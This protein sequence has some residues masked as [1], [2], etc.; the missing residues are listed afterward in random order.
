MIWSGEKWIESLELLYLMNLLKRSN[1]LPIHTIRTHGAA[2][3]C[4]I[5]SMNRPTVW[6][7]EHA[8][9]V[10][11]CLHQWQ[12]P[13]IKI[14]KKTL[15]LTTTDHIIIQYNRSTI[16]ACAAAAFLWIGKAKNEKR[17]KK[18]NQF[19]VCLVAALQR[20]ILS[21]FRSCWLLQCAGDDVGTTIHVPRTLSTGPSTN[22]RNQ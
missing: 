12:L 16:R 17:K 6:N 13:K 4:P 19:S 22:N 5:F 15:G 18:K 10:N 11:V 3:D 14:K 8:S 21:N 2:D 1:W 7:S 9:Y 20:V